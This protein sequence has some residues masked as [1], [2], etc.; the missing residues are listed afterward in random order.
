MENLLLTA[1]NNRTKAL[2]ELKRRRNKG[3]TKL[4]PGEEMKTEQRVYIDVMKM[5]RDYKAELEP[6]TSIRGRGADAGLCLVL[7]VA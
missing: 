5:L 7:Q 3:I 4:R 2:N 1:R 6:L